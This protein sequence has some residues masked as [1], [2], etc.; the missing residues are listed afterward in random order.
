[1]LLFLLATDGTNL[2]LWTE[3]SIQTPSYQVLAQELQ[4]AIPPGASVMDKGEWWFALRDRDL[5]DYMSV[6]LEGP[7]NY[8]KTNDPTDWAGE[9]RK[10]RWQYFIAYWDKALMFDLRVPIEEAI[11]SIYPGQK[12]D[13]FE[14]RSFVTSYNGPLLQVPTPF[15]PMVIF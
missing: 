8:Q 9:W 13:L 4:A 5:N 2:A 7:T 3:K 14:V 15:G 12:E 6:Q 1:M 10:Y 11:V